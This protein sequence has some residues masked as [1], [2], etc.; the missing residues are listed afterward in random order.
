M[1]SLW[2][3]CITV[4][5]VSYS[6]PCC[7]ILETIKPHL[8]HHTLG[9]V[10]GARFSFATSDCSSYNTEEIVEIVFYPDIMHLRNNL[11]WPNKNKFMTSRKYLKIVDIFS[12]I[13][14]IKVISVCPISGMS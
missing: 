11:S 5:V 6:S 1:L 9:K 14:Y 2:L 10:G 13:L 8:A 12:I 3:V 4:C 7:V